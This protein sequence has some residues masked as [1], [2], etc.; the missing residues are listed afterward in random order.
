M[1]STANKLGSRSRPFQSLRN[2]ASS[3]SEEQ[4]LPTEDSNGIRK[5]TDVELFYHAAGGDRQTKDG[6]IEMV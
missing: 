3:D 5:T 2:D 4:I 6:P 1:D